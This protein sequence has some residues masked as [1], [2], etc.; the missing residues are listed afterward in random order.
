LN[1]KNITSLSKVLCAG[2][3]SLGL[4]S[5]ANA[6]LVST[7]GGLAVYD[8]DRDIS[9]LANANAAAGSVFDDGST[10]T[11]GRLTWNNANAWAASLNVGG[12]TGWRLPSALNSDGTDPCDGLNCTDSELGH[13]FYNELSGTAGNSILTSGDLDLALFSNVQ[14][15]NYWSST[16]LAPAQNGAW[17][18]D[19]NSG[20]QTNNGLQ[21]TNFNNITLFAWAVH[22]GD[23]GA[24]AVPVPG[25][26]ALMGLGLAGLLGFG[27]RQ[28]LL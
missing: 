18:F 26:I 5:T 1:K 28:R 13:L 7:L 8:T 21:G 20:V 10:T 11:D 6:A 24:S 19:L 12:M 27:R 23:V 2:L 25:T 17:R 22:D 4:A 14:P 15:F 3:L 9:W 16:E